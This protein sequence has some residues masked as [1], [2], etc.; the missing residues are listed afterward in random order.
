M[1]L[2]SK[3]NIRSD[4]VDTINHQPKTD[5]LILNNRY[6]KTIDFNTKNE[7]KKRDK[8]SDTT[9]GQRPTGLFKSV[10]WQLASDLTSATKW[11]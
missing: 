1:N 11:C 7:P 9:L 2:P 4:K 8:L 3:T 10:N 5:N 6:D